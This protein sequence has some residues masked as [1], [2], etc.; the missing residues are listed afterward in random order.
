[1]STPT[2]EMSPLRAVR[3]IAAARWRTVRTPGARGWSWLGLAAGAMGLSLAAQAGDLVRL[4]A[5]TEGEASLIGQVANT[6]IRQWV[7][8]G[9]GS[10][11]TVVLLFAVASSVLV[12]MMSSSAPALMADHELAGVPVPSMTAYLGALVVHLTSL[13]TFVQLL[14]L[15]TLAGMLTID[16]RGRARAIALVWAAWLVLAVFAQCALW[17]S[18]LARSMPRGRL[19]AGAAAVAGLLAAG[20]LLV[21]G[22]AS[23]LFGVPRGFA[24]WLV[25]APLWASVLIALGAGLTAGAAGW[26]WCA[27]ALSIGT[28]TTRDATKDRRARAMP[29][30]ATWALISAVGRSFTRTRSIY[31]PL[32][33]ITVLAAAGAIAGGDL[34]ATSWSVGIGVPLA[35]GL[36]WTD[37]AAAMTGPAN[38]WIVSLPGQGRR[39]LGA[40]GVWAW[41]TSMVL[42]AAAWAPAVLLGRAGAAGTIST[43]ATAVAASSCVTAACLWHAV[44]RP[45]RARTDLGEA[46]LSPTATLGATLRLLAVPALGVWVGVAGVWAGRGTEATP[47]RQLLGAGVCVAVSAAWLAFT[48]ARWAN[49][50]VRARCLAGAS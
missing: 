33:I 1:M 4:A 50:R 23:G 40:W 12:P 32:A 8:N 36:A 6:Y 28:A 16:G 22:G 11:T 44:H 10:L 47:A 35:V 5:E 17:G 13:A 2:L 43:L 41:A 24:W 9:F 27:R 18:R 3:L 37:N 29:T 48:W 46:M 21:P 7:A 31:S 45:A 42:T 19:A 30:T 20:S 26:S 49:P 38:G 14:G 25:D 15:T 39:L 34:A